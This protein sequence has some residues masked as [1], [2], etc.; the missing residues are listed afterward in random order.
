[1]TF[2]H[3][4][5]F[6]ILKTKHPPPW[7]LEE[8]EEDDDLGYTTVSRALDLYLY[9]RAQVQKGY[10]ICKEYSK[11]RKAPENNTKEKQK[12]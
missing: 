7:W 12:L 8:E 9:L 11:T 3:H 1:M 5:E 4:N 6:S 10:V 2:K